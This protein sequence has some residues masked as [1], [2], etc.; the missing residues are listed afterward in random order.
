[1]IG[2]SDRERYVTL[3]KMKKQ[4]EPAYKK[5]EKKTSV[6]KPGIEPGT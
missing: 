2:S 5:S 3:R 6:H 4:I 1:M